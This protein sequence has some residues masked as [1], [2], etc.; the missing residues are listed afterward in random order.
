MILPG[1]TVTIKNHTYIYCGY[2]GFVQ[3]ISGTNAEVIFNKYS[4]WKTKSNDPISSTTFISDIV[5]DVINARKPNYYK[6]MTKREFD[7]ITW[8]CESVDYASSPLIERYGIVGIDKKYKWVLFFEFDHVSNSIGDFDE[9]IINQIGENGIIDESINHKKKFT[10]NKLMS[11]IKN[12]QEYLNNG[13][14]FSEGYQT[15]KQKDENIILF[16]QL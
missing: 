11:V 4:T 16:N 5:L 3:R 8:V 7:G 15:V 6:K 9:L 14:K 10:K 1:T 2:V 13:V 12:A